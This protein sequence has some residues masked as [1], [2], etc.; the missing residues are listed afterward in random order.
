MASVLPA[1]PIVTIACCHFDQALKT[2]VQRGDS[3][4]D[5]ERA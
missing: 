3:I 5:F 1:I 4:N 2:R